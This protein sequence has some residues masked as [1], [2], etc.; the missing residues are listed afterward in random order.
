MQELNRRK[1]GSKSYDRKASFEAITKDNFEAITKANFEAITKDNCEAIT[2]ANF[3]AITKA[4][5]ESIDTKVRKSPDDNPLIR[6]PS[7]RM[8]SRRLL[9]FRSTSQSR[10]WSTT[11]N[12]LCKYFA[13]TLL[14]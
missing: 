6:Y 12:C 7:S 1:H 2:K 8:C 13:V 10:Q 11:S 14:R 4:I 3:E 9:L 5:F